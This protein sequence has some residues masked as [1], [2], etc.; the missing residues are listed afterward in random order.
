MAMARVGV[1]FR[2]RRFVVVVNYQAGDGFV[3]L[4]SLGDGRWRGRK[5]RKGFTIAVCVFQQIFKD[6]VAEEV[7]LLF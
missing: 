3:I 6:E 5:G 1:G 7:I 4:G 2:F